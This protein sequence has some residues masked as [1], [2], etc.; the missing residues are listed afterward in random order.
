MWN[1]LVY[2]VRVLSTYVHYRL[3]KMAMCISLDLLKWF[4]IY[5]LPMKHWKATFWKR[6]LR[7]F[8]LCLFMSLMSFP[9]AK[10][11]SLHFFFSTLKVKNGIDSK[12]QKLRTNQYLAKDCAAWR[13]ECSKARQSDVQSGHPETCSHRDVTATWICNWGDVKYVLDVLSKSSTECIN[14][15]LM[16][17]CSS[18]Q[19]KELFHL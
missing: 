11:F 13:V 1:N 9:V 14:S 7:T 4:Q 3:T 18:E 8:S 6:K 2:S 15:A 10:D 17:N 5:K 19:Y 12:T 16:W